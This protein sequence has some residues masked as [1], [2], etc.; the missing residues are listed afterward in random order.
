MLP[1]AGVIEVTSAVT[2][3]LDSLTFIKALPD[4]SNKTTVA[5]G[6]LETDGVEES[7]HEIVTLSV[8]DK[9]PHS[10][11]PAKTVTAPL[12]LET[13][14]LIFDPDLRLDGRVSSET[15]GVFSGD[16]MNSAD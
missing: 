5:F 9:E 10:A 2:V 11:S 7:E 12:M 13:V 8:I 14:R 3:A 15:T 4:S 16:W 6:E 1:C